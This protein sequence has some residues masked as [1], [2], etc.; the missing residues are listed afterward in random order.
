MVKGINRAVIEVSN[1]DNPYIERAILFVNPNFANKSNK[2]VNDEA[3]R[4]LKSLAL[5][6]YCKKYDEKT[7]KKIKKLS[8]AMKI[9]SASSIALVLLC[10]ALLITRL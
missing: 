10:V 2:F 7:T 6:E 8:N 9:L 3:K 1:T 5:P 4:Y